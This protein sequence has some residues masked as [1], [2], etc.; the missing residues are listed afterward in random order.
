[1]QLTATAVVLAVLIDVAAGQLA[2]SLAELLVLAFIFT[3][4]VPQVTQAQSNVQTLAQSLPAFDELTAVID[5]CAR[6]AEGG[7]PQ[8]ALRSPTPHRRPLALSDRLSPRSV[9]LTCPFPTGGRTA[10]RSRC[11]T[12]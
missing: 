5:D 8:P 4:L 9:R 11:C 1:M 3:R 2:L 7:E 12:A 10:S 6:A